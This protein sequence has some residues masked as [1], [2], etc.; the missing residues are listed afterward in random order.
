MVRKSFIVLLALLFSTAFLG[1]A[2]KVDIYFFYS[3]SCD[4]CEEIQK[5]ILRPLVEQYSD[6][7]E[8]EEFEIEDNM[9]N[10]EKLIDM[11][12]QYG[13]EGNTIPV[14]FVGD[15]VFG[16]EEDFV[17]YVKRLI[18]AARKKK[19][20]AAADTALKKPEAVAV[21]DST[22]V[23]RVAKPEETPRYPVFLAYFWEPGCQ[24]CS[25]VTYDLELLEKRHPTLV[26]RDWNIE[27]K[28][29]K[30]YAEA[31]AMRLDVPERLHLATPAIF[32]IDTAFIAEQISF[33]A[34][35]EAI[36]RLEKIPDT[37]TVWSF[38]EEE[39]E[40]ADEVIIKR[41]RSL[42]AAPV[43]AAG[44]LDGL[45]PCAF[46]AIIFFITF[47]TVVK[48]KKSE[49]FW[50]GVAFTF[51]VF[52]TYL[53]IGAGFLRFLQALP[54]LKTFARWVYLVMSVVVVGLGL[55]S[56]FDFFRSL[57]GEYGDMVLQLPDSLKNRIHRVIISENEPRARR[58]IIFAA[59]TTGFL[60][61]VLEL[62]CTGQVYL[63]T[64]IYVMGAPGLKTKAYLFLIL[65]NLMFI[66][67]LV[68]VFA[69]VFW[70]TT[71]EQ[72]T[73]FLKRN[74]PIIKL[75]TAGIFF[76]M[77]FFMWRTVLGA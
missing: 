30:R 54:F 33:R 5:N 67:P 9:D 36:S 46:G 22:P 71:S 51:S 56:I 62:A 7:L 4:H 70:G 50:V 77:A 3:K 45:N 69:V 12:V 57:K 34:V 25:R 68:A 40:K 8:L 37:D 16:G 1:A 23:E 35:D 2:D 59:I 29:A 63:P 28:E 6:V 58:N 72:L 18:A 13:D 15:S 31:L 47:L 21:V 26:V 65:Y 10:Y 32:L 74:T 19:A 17:P 39:I 14:T 52:F 38:S 43:I 27:K 24:H 41:F 73:N 64:I 55:L 60:V 42:E 49:I 53:L 20:V 44:L 11:E 66:V 76:A 75:L 61:S 48:R